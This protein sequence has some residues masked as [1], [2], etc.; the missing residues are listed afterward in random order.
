MAFDWPLLS[1][2]TLPNLTPKPCPDLVEHYLH[3]ILTSVITH[4]YSLTPT[5]RT[6]P[7]TLRRV[8]AQATQETSNVSA[9]ICPPSL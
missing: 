9:P 2:L 1:A 8:S 7:N 4:S 3:T 6:Y 5:L